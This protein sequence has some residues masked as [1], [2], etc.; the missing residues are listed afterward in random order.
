MNVTSAASL[1]PL[2]PAFVWSRF[3]TEAGEEFDAILARKERERS[4]DGGIFYWGIGNSVGRAVDLLSRVCAPQVVF[5]P[6]AS[7]ARNEDVS[8]AS[9]VRWTHA[10]DWLRFGVEM[11]AHAVVTSRGDRACHYALVCQSSLPLRADGHQ[12]VHVDGFTNFESGS[13]VGA[14]QTTA[15]VRNAN[16]QSGRS[17]RVALRVE[18][19]P[20]YFV[21]L[22]DPEVVPLPSHVPGSIPN[23]PPGMVQAGLPLTPSIPC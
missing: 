10:E 12:R 13:P 8:P 23:T 14:S 4:L 21:R 16:L 5:S 9:I 17:Y 18:L 19:V 22:L 20:P 6:I 2:G 1:P 11:P 7:R 15:V 3:G